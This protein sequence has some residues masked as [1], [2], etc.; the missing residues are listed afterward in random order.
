LM[1]M[2]GV[3]LFDDKTTILMAWAYKYTVMSYY[4]YKLYL[5]L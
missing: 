4:L 1:S 5:R 3:S 2:H